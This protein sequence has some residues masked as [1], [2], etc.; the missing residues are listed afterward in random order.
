MSAQEYGPINVTE[1]THL[2]LT[3][4]DPELFEI[5]EWVKDCV[6]VK[7]LNLKHN[8]IKNIKASDLPPKIE[9]LNL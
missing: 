7:S 6:N 4:N 2:D 3:L 1:I 9:R 8:S 5:P